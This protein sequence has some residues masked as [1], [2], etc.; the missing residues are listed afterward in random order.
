MNEVC[1]FFVERQINQMEN[2]IFIYY[3]MKLLL[4]LTFESLVFLI[5]YF[6]D[7]QWQYCIDVFKPWT[8]NLKEIPDWL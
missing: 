1:F 5:I 8:E 7:I 6:D 3:L 2:I 4:W